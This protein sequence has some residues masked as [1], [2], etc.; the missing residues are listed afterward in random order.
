MERL[1][2][3]AAAKLSGLTT[4]TLRAWERRYS[5]IEPFRTE[6]GRRLYSMKD[7]EKLSLLATLT[8]SGH[9]IGELAKLSIKELNSLLNAGMKAKTL[10]YKQF[11]AK[12]DLFSHIR[13]SLN[14][15]VRSLDFEE[16]DRLILQARH[17]TSVRSFVLEVVSPLLVEVGKLVSKN[18]IDIAQEHALSAIL[19]THLGE[20]LMQV[21]KTSAW[22]SKNNAEP[23]RLLFSTPE[24]DL[25]EFGILLAAILSG[26]RGFKFRYLGPNMP[27]E[28]LAKAAIT[29]G[30]QIIVI[31]SVE[32]DEGRLA[33]PLSN[34]VRILA[35]HLSENNS[36][37]VSIWIGGRCDFDISSIRSKKKI[38]HTDSL[39]DF[40]H[41]LES[42]TA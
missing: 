17:S 18:T 9:S 38:I 42:L 24:G 26:T 11:E 14:L 22:S 5:V 10:S 12:G 2:V 19:R 32:A 1:S 4:H 37:E 15:A 40:D 7:V 16:L 21:Q 13:S 31:G 30:A 25:H 23:P 8:E 3:K 39:V 6:S 33:H 27:A 34:Y 36:Q 20:L 29:V 28:S 35:H 41:R